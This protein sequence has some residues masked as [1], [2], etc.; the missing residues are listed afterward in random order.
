MQELVLRSQPSSRAYVNNQ[1]GD[2][3]SSNDTSTTASRDAAGASISPPLL[4]G[5]IIAACLLF[6]LLIVV[7]LRDMLKRRSDS[8]SP[9][10][11]STST[12]SSSAS[13]GSSTAQIDRASKAESRRKRLLKLDIVA[14]VQELWGWRKAKAHSDVHANPIPAEIVFCAICQDIIDEQDSIRELQCR[15]IYHSSCLD[16]WFGKGHSDCPLC[17]TDILG[18]TTAVAGSLVRESD[19]LGS[20]NSSTEECTTAVTGSTFDAVIC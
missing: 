7:G 18:D 4:V 16:R 12:S 9:S 14:P 17:K 3:S 10:S 19:E 6:G 1:G 2:T 8:R 5:I 15:H 11:A 20:D 13:S